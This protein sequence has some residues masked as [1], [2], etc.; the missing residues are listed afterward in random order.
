MARAAHRQLT[1]ADLLAM[2]ED[3]LRHELIDGEHYVTASPNTKHQRVSG[4]LHLEIG[5][6]LRGNP[7][8]ELFS[9][10]YDVFFTPIDVVVPDLVFIA[11]EHF[12]RITERNLQGAPDL[13]IEIL[14][15]STSA[16]DEGVKRRLYERQ[17][18]AE[19]W[20]VDPF[21]DAV[22][23][24]RRGTGRK[25][26]LAADLSAEDGGVLTTPLLPG[27]AIALAEIFA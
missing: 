7:L 25:L 20:L 19:Y 15:P 6:F 12:Q 1:Y 27:L 9:A 8:G 21:V 10:P 13:A 5:L 22:R 17:G 11:R 26:V 3:G 2:P 14:S 16:I 4:R 23:I 18:V 24:F